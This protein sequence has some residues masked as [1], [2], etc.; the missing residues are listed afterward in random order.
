MFQPDPRMIKKQVESLIDREYL[1]RDTVSGFR[2]QGLV[3]W[4]CIHSAA[5]PHP[6][7]CAS[8]CRMLLC[9]AVIRHNGTAF[10]CA[11][12]CGF[13]QQHWAHSPPNTQC[14][15]FRLSSAQ[16]RPNTFKYVA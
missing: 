8:A 7:A 16:E 14:A 4:P 5:V 3:V 9:D 6:T 2:V 11:A 13:A 10:V 15:N 1:E 12:I